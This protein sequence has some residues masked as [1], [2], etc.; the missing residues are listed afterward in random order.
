LQLNDDNTTI[1]PF[2][3]R[4]LI[5]ITY[6]LVINVDVMSEKYWCHDCTCHVKI[7]WC[8][9]C[10]CHVWKT[11]TSDMTYTFMTSA[12]FRN[13]IV[14]F[15]ISHDIYIYDSSVFQTWQQHLWHQCTNNSA[16]NH[17]TEAKRKFYLYYTLTY[18]ISS[19][20]LKA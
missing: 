4:D 1:G 3:L 17:W 20:Y 7:H 14:I 2:V 16:K 15:F 18:Q 9:R 10:R 5:S 12:Y 19:Q 6:L 11:L 8:H 13:D